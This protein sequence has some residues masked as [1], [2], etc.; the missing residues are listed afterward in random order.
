MSVTKNTLKEIFE[1]IKK[2]LEDAGYDLQQDSLVREVQFLEYPG[3]K[4]TI[5]IGSIFNE[6]RAPTEE[7]IN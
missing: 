5:Q 1:E 3:I 6:R 4:M 7:E 2:D